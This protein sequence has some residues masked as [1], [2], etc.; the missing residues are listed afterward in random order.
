MPAKDLDL[1]A[2]WGKES[3]TITFDSKGVAVSPITA[4]YGVD[5]RS[6][7]SGQNGV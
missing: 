2:K 7:K 5:C 6:G 1:Y 3:Y 4:E